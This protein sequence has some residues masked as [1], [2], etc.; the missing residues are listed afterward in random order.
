MR[1]GIS[2]SVSLCPPVLSLCVVPPLRRGLEKR[3]SRRRLHESGAE[4]AKKEKESG[5]G[6][7][8]EKHFV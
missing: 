5:R 1:M 2:P 7:A 6:K 3:S 8:D 4:A